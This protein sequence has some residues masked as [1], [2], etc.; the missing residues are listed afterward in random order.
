VSDP[1]PKD[2]SVGMIDMSLREL[3]LHMASKGLDHA[4]LV[5]PGNATRVSITLANEEKMRRI[6]R[7][8]QRILTP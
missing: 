2:I 6:T 8:V 3:L 4:V 5:I 1:T 7:E